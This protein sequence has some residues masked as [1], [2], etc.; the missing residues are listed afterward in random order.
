MLHRHRLATSKGAILL[1]QLAELVGRNRFHAVLRGFLRRFA[2]SAASWDDL[3]QALHAET[4]GAFR[5]WADQ[6]LRRP[7]APRL[8]IDHSISG[9][10]VT[11]ELRQAGEPYRLSVPVEL[12]GA[13][14]RER[15]LIETSSAYRSVA[16][17]A[18][19]PVESVVVDPDALIP[20]LPMP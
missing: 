1:R 19:G 11:L 9:R 3:E 2:G 13:W 14:G 16:H 6:W 4:G 5:W 12:R 10:T 20:R 8:R 18:G 15:V 7:G 17:Q